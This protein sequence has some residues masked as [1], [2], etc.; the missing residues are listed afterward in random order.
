MLTKNPAERFQTAYDLLVGV[1]EVWTMLAV[2][3]AKMG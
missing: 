1:D 3:V 2:R